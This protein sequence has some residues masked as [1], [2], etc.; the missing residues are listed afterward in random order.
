MLEVNTTDTEHGLTMRY[1]GDIQIKTY[2]FTSRHS[3]EANIK[4]TVKPATQMIL[5]TQ[6]C[7]DIV[8]HALTRFQYW[9]Q[10]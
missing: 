1:Q 3:L 6:C 8:L 2:A 9:H 4:A 5:A 7:K 10:K